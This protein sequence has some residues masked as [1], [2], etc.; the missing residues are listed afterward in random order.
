MQY[1]C[2][3]LK[4]LEDVRRDATLN[5][6]D[7][8]EV[9]D[10]DA[11][12]NSPPQQ[13][14]VVYLLKQPATQLTRDQVHIEG[15]VRITPV[16]VVWAYTADSIPNKL[17]NQEEKKFFAKLD[18]PEKVLIVRTDSSGDFSYYT[19]RLVNS[20]TDLSPPKN[21]DPLISE[22]EFSFKVECGS[23]FDCKPNLV[24]PPARLDEP[25]ISY[26]AKDYSSFRRLILDRLATVM[27]DWIERNPADLG[28]MLVEVLAYA[29]DQLSYYQDSVA[30]EAY[31]GTARRR[32]SLRRHARLLDYPLFDGKNARAWVCFEVS[33]PSSADGHTFPTSTQLFT[34]VNAPRG[35][36]DQKVVEAAVNQGAEFFETLHEFTPRSAHNRILFYTW[37]DEE[38]CLPI[39]ATKA[40]LDNINGQLAL[41]PSDV[42]ILEELLNPEGLDGDPSHRHAVRLTKVTP[43]VDQLTNHKVVEVEWSPDDALPFPLCFSARVVDAGGVKLVPDLCVAR[44][45]IVLADHG[46]RIADDD[47]VPALVPGQGPYRPVLKKTDVIHRAPYDHATAKTKPASQ[48]MIQDSQRILPWVELQLNSNPWVVQPHLLN[49]DRFASDFVVEM[50][51]DGIAHLRFGDNM[52]GRSPPAASNFK[53]TFRVGRESAGN[54]GAEAIAHVVTLVDGVTNVRN[55][56]PAQ[57]GTNGEPLERVRLDAPEAFRIQQRAVTQADYE[58]VSERD[59]EVQRAA[60]TLRWTGSWHTMYVTVDPKQSEI[61]G[62]K[63][64]ADFR[65]YLEQFRLAGHDLEVEPPVYVPLDIAMTICVAPGYYLEVVQSELLQIFSNVDLPDGRRGFFHPDNFTFGQPVYLSQVVSAAMQVPGIQWVDADESQPKPNRFRRIGAAAG[66]EAVEG[67]ISLGRL[68]IARLDNDPNYPESG[69]IEFFMEGGI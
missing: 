27:P 41:S 45:N 38:C 16:N 9:L 19:L 67:Q 57:G 2:K 58:D 12:A 32:I 63:F 15:G 5:G 54:V 60:A 68:E 22:I 24:C 51:N 40:T 64:Q 23:D 44:G 47:L 26:L 61:V 65:K 10:S 34:H 17:I 25:E 11:P 52:Y 35:G 43:S 56:L 8:L 7:Y 39:G 36:V 20:L 42:L 53:V 30:T 14:L 29:G 21:F 55:P 28:V 66:S 3:T 4:R 6:I 59:P 31:L 18:H 48:A 1:F 13:T 46:L 49:S 33:S 37:D 50:E 62:S 69:R